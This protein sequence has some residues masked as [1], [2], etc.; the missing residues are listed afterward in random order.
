MV[1]VTEGKSILLEKTTSNNAEENHSECESRVQKL[2]IE[3]VALMDHPAVH[4]LQSLWYLMDAA[5]KDVGHNTMTP[6]EATQESGCRI[7]SPGR[8]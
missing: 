4:Q 1:S 3:S 5:I 8:A 7:H 6:T 2:R